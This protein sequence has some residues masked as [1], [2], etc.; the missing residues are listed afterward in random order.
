M[1]SIEVIFIRNLMHFLIQVY[2]RTDFS[3]KNA[4]HGISAFIIE[5]NFDGFKTGPKLD[6]LGMRGSNTSEIIF[7]NCKVPKENLLGDENRG[8]YVLMSGLD[9]ERLVL[10]GGP[11]GVMQACCDVAFHHARMR[12]PF[13]G[14]EEEF[15]FKQVS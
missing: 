9:L 6:K 14:I 3:T 5:K 13:N 1:R 4:K 12:K 10:A 2:A 11:L 15:Q 7:E 8:I